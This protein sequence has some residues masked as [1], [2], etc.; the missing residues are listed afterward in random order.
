MEPHNAALVFELMLGGLALALVFAALVLLPRQAASWRVGFAL[1]VFLVAEAAMVLLSLLMLPQQSEPLSPKLRLLANFT[2][3]VYGLVIITTFLLLVVLA[4]RL[5]DAFSVLIRAELVLW[6]LFQIPLWQSWLF[7][8][9]AMTLQKLHM[10]FA[11]P[12]AVYMLLVTL[13]ALAV[14]LWFAYRYRAAI[15]CKTLLRAAVLSLFIHTPVLVLPLAVG[16][17]MAAWGAGVVALLLLYGWRH[18]PLCALPEG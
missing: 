1:G 11:Q 15:T 16:T 3:N 10:D 9:D 12:I 6:G 13:A 18:D 7:D 8:T 4:D 2:V 14:A 17:I 5:T